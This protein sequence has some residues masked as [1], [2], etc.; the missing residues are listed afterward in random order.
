[1]RLLLAGLLLVA[2]SSLAQAKVR[3]VATTTDLMDIA[4]NV[5]GDRVEVSVL[6]RGMDN[7]H[8]VEPRPSQVMKLTHAD[9][10]LRIGMDLDMWVDGLIDAARN[11]K[12]ARGSR[13]Y[14][15]CST[16]IRRL[17][18]PTGRLDPS[19]GDIH[20]Y[21]NPHYW[22]DPENG[23]IIARNVLNALQRTDPTNAEHYAA[24]YRRYASEIDER[25]RAWEQLLGRFRGAKVV[26]YHKSFIYFLKRFGLTEF[27]NVEP[28]P[29]IPPSP[30]HVSELIRDMKASGVK[31]IIMEPF[32]EKKYP[33]LIARSTGAKVVIVPPSVNSIK[34]MDTYLEVIDAVVRR[35][36]EALGS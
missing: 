7:P 10:L 11:G 16:G 35:V 13:G 14:V 33:D 19:M 30:S 2:G 36:A 24:N 22:L 3:I 32:Y 34:G 9:L 17:E 23:K 4:R 28:K 31:A 8:V 27:G 15:D 26:T 21:G 29:G 6:S 1:M 25:T 5:G 12:I 20:V 18:I